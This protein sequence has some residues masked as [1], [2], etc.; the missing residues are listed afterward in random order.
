LEQSGEYRIDASREAVWEALNDPDILGACITGCQEV[1]R[2]DEQHFD[3]KVKAKVGPVSATFQAALELDDLNP[4]ESY[5]INGAV[6]GGPAGFGK[7]SARVSLEEDGAGTHLRYQVHANVGGKLAQVGSRLVDGAARKMA[8]EFFAAFSQ[9][10]TS[11]GETA[12]EAQSETDASAS[13]PPGEAQPGTYESSGK[14]V[15]W[16][17]AFVVLAVAI[18]LAI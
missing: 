7:G 17:I 11:I 2:I 14:G 3:V 13:R 15:I 8:D 9:R 4:P 10:L 16:A 6:K 5:V 18:I 1:Q 12:T